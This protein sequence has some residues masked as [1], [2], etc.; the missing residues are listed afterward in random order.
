[1]L[2]CIDISVRCLSGYGSFCS[3]PL[4]FLKLFLLRGLYQFYTQP[5]LAPIIVLLF[6]VLFKLLENKPNVNG[7]QRKLWIQKAL[8]QSSF[9]NTLTFILSHYLKL[10]FP[11]S[12]PDEPLKWQYVDQFVSESVV[13]DQY[14]V[15]CLLGICNG[16]ETLS[17]LI[18][19]EKLL[20]HYYNAISCWKYSVRN[21]FCDM[22]LF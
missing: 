18:L 12:S 9:W 15:K 3:L 14:F 16:S 11:F 20:M 2:L 19:S 8:F 21:I 10:F 7:I 5:L 1:M 22:K 13:R 17:P 4:R 6:N